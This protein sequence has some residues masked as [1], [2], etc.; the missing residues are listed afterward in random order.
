MLLMVSVLSG[1]HG[2]VRQQHARYVI[3]ECMAA[4]QSL[5]RSPPGFARAEEFI[6]RIRAVDTSGAPGD[7][8]KALHDH[9]DALERSIAAA[10]RKYW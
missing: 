5:E 1:A 8:V 6:R 7:L 2:I 4:T 3:R 10:V 9:A